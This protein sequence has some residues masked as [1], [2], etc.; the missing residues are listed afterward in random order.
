MSS[1]PARLLDRYAGTDN[2]E[3]AQVVAESAAAPA[4]GRRRAGEVAPGLSVAVL[5]LDRPDLII[6]LIERLSGA[7][8]AFAA[9]LVFTGP[10]RFSLD[11][12]IGAERREARAERRLAKRAASR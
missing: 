5:T 12:L 10:G 2:L 1:R 7:A 11:H 4:G 3:R 6:P 9:V 8:A